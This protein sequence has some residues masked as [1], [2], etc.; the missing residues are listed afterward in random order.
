M[1]VFKHVSI[2]GCVYTGLPAGEYVGGSADPIPDSNIGSRLLQSMG[3]SPG[4]GL[5]PAGSGITVPVM[6]FKR[7]GRKGL[8]TALPPSTTS[9]H[10]QSSE[11][12]S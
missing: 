3:W 5:G 4:S 10:H 9:T 8:G 6:A 2:N 11:K 7:L 12:N 1:D